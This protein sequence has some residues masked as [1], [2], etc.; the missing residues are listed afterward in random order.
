MLI[1]LWIV[2]VIISLAVGYAFGIQVPEVDARKYWK[3]RDY[4]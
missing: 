1:G 2:S 3:W 4:K